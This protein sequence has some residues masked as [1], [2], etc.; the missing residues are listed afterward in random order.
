MGYMRK[1]LYTIC[2]KKFVKSFSLYI[3][4]SLDSG[5]ICDSGSLV[6]LQNVLMYYRIA[7]RISVLAVQWNDFKIFFALSS[8]FLDFQYI[9]IFLG[10]R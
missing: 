3:P 5:V 1:F 9:K 8:S 10:K 2:L 6:L 4:F 7:K